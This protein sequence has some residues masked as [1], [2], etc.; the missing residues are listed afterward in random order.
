MR[1][2][3]R[4]EIDGKTFYYVYCRRRW[5]EVSEEVYS[6]VDGNERRWRYLQVLEKQH[7]A[8]SVDDLNEQ[9]NDC[10]LSI[11]PP[12]SIELPSAEEEFIRENDEKI[13]AMIPQIISS[14]IMNLD[15]QS[16]EIANSII[17]NGE[18]LQYCSD[19]LG[20]PQTSLWR[21]LK[22]IR[23][24]L[25]KDCLEVLHNEQQ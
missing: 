1:K 21:K 11:K 16:R 10:E 22:L 17:V 20:I 25:Y 5:I 18:S 23:E 19:K 2:T 8:M 6:F 15:Q 4:I 9:L 24:K 3:K 14:Q 13:C 7:R 12:K